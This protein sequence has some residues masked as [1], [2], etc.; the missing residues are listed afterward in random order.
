[1]DTLTRN[2]RYNAGGPVTYYL[3]PTRYICTPERLTFT[4]TQGNFSAEAVRVRPSAT[5]VHSNDLV[6]R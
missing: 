3:E 6:P 5:P 1:V 2:G 4:S